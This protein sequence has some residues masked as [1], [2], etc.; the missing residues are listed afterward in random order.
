MHLEL[1]ALA[2]VGLVDV[3]ARA[4][5]PGVDTAELFGSP[6]DA[7]D[8]VEAADSSEGEQEK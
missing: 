4:I 6:A 8:E 2:R 3:L 7:P 1:V 5:Q